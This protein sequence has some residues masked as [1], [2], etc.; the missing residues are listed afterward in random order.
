LT[1]NTLQEEPLLCQ[2]E[3]ASPKRRRRISRNELL[4]TEIQ[5]ERKEKVEKK[6]MFFL[7]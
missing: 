5:Q 3:N 6:K 2:G 1:K 4:A 7:E